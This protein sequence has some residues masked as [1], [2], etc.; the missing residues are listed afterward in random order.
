MFSKFIG[1]TQ[2]LQKTNLTDLDIFRNIPYCEKTDE[3][4]TDFHEIIKNLFLG[5]CMCPSGILQIKNNQY[6]DYQKYSDFDD[7]NNFLKELST[8]IQAGPSK[9]FMLTEIQEYIDK[10]NFKEP[11]LIITYPPTDA[12]QQLFKIISKNPDKYLKNTILQIDDDLKNNK[13][14]FVHCEGGI[15]RSATIIAAYIMAK[16]KLSADEVQKYMGYIR[17]G[18]NNKINHIESKKFLLQHQ[19]YLYNLL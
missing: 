10:K 8:I 3:Y 2:N 13:K 12:P 7:V 1:S 17:P 16:W 4:N 6:D 19:N 5:G 11:N 15:H 18:T 9:H 14:V